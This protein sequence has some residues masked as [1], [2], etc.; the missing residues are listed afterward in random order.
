M[1]NVKQ[2]T[3]IWGSCL[4]MNSSLYNLCLN[5]YILVWFAFCL[6][7][8]SLFLQAQGHYDF[9]IFLIFGLQF[10]CHYL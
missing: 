5:I 8:Y 4:R 3:G 1:K 2:G 9:T 6:T 7:T 10:L